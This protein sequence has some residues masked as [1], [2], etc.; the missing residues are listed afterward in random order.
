MTARHH[1]HLRNTTI[2][3][4]SL[5]AG[6]VAAAL[7][8]YT[9]ADPYAFTSAHAVAT[10]GDAP[11]EIAAD[12]P[13]SRFLPRL[14]GRAV[15]EATELDLAPMTI[16]GH[17]PR[18]FAKAKLES[19]PSCVAYW[20]T[21]ESGPIG[22][23]VL[24]TCPGARNVPPPPVSTLSSPG[25]LRLPTI[26]SFNEQLPAMQLPADLVPSA[27]DADLASAKV[28]TALRLRWH[29][30]QEGTAGG[31]REVGVLP[32]LNPLSWAPTKG[33]AS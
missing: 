22:R 32:I 20:R 4:A 28:D 5:S 2:A 14:D 23:H 1:H 12:Q 27:G 11:T 13:G 21:L 15:V 31:A 7:A 3:V 6:L 29:G 33:R 16:F 8:V 25:E 24:V 18:H 10:D 19:K 30:V 26:T 9:Q 17:A